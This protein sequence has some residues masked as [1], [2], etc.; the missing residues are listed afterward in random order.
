MTDEFYCC[1]HCGAFEA[2]SHIKYAFSDFPRWITEEE[3]EQIA[4]ILG[5]DADDFNP[6]EINVCNNCGEDFEGL[7]VASTE[8][9]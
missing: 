4:E 5:C 8:R 7:M 1:E 2:G 9:Y 3:L 6:E